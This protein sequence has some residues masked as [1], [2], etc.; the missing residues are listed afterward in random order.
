MKKQIN[1]SQPE[2]LDKRL[3]DIFSLEFLQPSMILDQKGVW[4]KWNDEFL[5][6]TKK[7]ITQLINQA[8][9]D[10]VEKAQKNSNALHYLQH[11]LTYLKS[12]KDK[13]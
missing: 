9:I 8:R 3:D 1:N 7:A 12:P 6:D 4:F 13:P 10:E 2:S 11:R 5:R